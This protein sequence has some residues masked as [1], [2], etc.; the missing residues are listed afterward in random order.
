M[1]LNPLQILKI[2]NTINDFRARHPGFA[3]FIKAIRKKG[4]P[5][6]SVLEV[7]IT[8]PEGQTMET[9]IRVS[10][11][12]LELLRTLSDLANS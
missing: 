10:E 7:K 1:A 11:E 9:N 5:Q 8:F 3:R 6:G 4:L 12:D 2:K